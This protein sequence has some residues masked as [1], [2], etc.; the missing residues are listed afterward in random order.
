M[1]LSEWAPAG[2]R[3]EGMAAV[4]LPTGWEGG[5]TLQHAS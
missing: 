3:L 1:D 2:A 5:Q 4:P